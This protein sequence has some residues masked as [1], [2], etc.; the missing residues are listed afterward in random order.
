M[1]VADQKLPTKKRE[2]PENYSQEVPGRFRV[3]RRDLTKLLQ[4]VD[5]ALDF[6]AF[7]VNDLV[8]FPWFDQGPPIGVLDQVRPG[9]PPVP[10]AQPGTG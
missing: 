8:V 4:F 3:S 2:E 5:T 9:I 7:L 6:V 1:T 10:L